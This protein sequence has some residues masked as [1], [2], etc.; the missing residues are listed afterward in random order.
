MLNVIQHRREDAPGVVEALVS[1][2]DTRKINFTGSTPVGSIVAQ[3][4]GKYL[5]PLLL[6]LG[7]KAPVIVLDDADLPKAAQQALIGA[8]AHVSSLQTI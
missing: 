6:E 2:P 3:L 7:G 5:K 8:W 1:H 4:A